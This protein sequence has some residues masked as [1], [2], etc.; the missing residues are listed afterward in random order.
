MSTAIDIMRV[1]FGI[2]FLCFASYT[3]LKTRRVKNEIWMLMGFTGGVFLLLQLF[4]DKKTWEYFLILVP[5]GILFASM[6]IEHEPLFDGE[7][8]TFN[9]KFFGLYS[10]GI[11]VVIYQIYALSGETYFYHLLAIPILIVFFFVLYQLRILHGGADA[12]AMMAI[13]IFV[14]FY[15]YFFD[16]PLLQISPERVASAMELFFPFAFLVLMNSVIFVI[17]VFLAFLV[18]NSAKRDFGLPEM[19]LG[20]RIDIDKVEE[21]FVWPMERIVKG[22]RVMV[23][24]PKRNNEESLDKLRELG[25]KRIWITP[26]IPFIVFLT[27]GFV[28]SVFIGNLFAGIIGLFT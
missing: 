10:V 3:D 18:Y 17:W 26:K 24:F 13:A 11:A 2:A 16:F 7:K 25:V 15:P 9:F 27:A 19:L 14:P 12:K 8:R 5:V 1:V 21:K 23:L 28:I 22:E 4:L 6:F 20:Y